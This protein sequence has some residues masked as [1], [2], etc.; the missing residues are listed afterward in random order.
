MTVLA[1]GGPIPGRAGPALCVLHD[2][3]RQRILEELRS[4]WRRKMRD[5]HTPLDLSGE[6]DVVGERLNWLRRSGVI[7]DLEHRF[8]QAQLTPARNA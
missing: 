4:R 6:P 5:L 7:T 1:V 8:Y 2:A 3:Q